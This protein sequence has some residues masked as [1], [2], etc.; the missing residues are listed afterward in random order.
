MQA[1]CRTH[2]IL[3]DGTLV[4]RNTVIDDQL[5]PEKMR[6]KLDYEDLSEHE[7]QVM[8]V[9]GLGFC[10]EN[11]YWMNLSAGELIRLEDIPVRI[12]ENLK[13]GVDYIVNWT[14]KDHLR[15]REEE[16]QRELKM[17]QPEPLEIDPGWKVI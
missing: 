4:K 2:I 9:H 6:P 5:V 7:E 14:Q 11:G 15:L 3:A 8:L 10:G 13:E 12:R 17:L 16:T 1:R